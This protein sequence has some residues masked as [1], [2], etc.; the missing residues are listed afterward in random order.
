MTTLPN[1]R[2]EEIQ[3]HARQW[4]TL[5]DPSAFTQQD[6]VDL[7]AEREVLYRALTLDRRDP[8]RAVGGA[9]AGDGELS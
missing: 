7:L 6:L 2:L 4:V 9:A 1:A 3:V 8:V 5:G